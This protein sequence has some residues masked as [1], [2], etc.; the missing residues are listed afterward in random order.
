MKLLKGYEINL[1]LMRIELKSNLVKRL[2]GSIILA[3][4]NSATRHLRAKSK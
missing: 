4:V 3:F 1:F 2:A